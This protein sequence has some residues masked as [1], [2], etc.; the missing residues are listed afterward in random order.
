MRA[1][2]QTTITKSGLS[3]S[4]DADRRTVNPPTAAAVHRS[5]LGVGFSRVGGGLGLVEGLGLIGVGG[6]CNVEQAAQSLPLLTTFFLS[7]ELRCW[8]GKGPAK[9][10][11]N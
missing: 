6:G 4:A 9:R 10:K 8:G 1:N 11:K 7:L 5:F 2:P 3:N